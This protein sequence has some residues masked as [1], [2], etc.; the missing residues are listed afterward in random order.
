[1]TRD[2]SVWKSDQGCRETPLEA[3]MSSSE[4]SKIEPVT[5]AEATA[6]AM[7]QRVLSSWASD[8]LVLRRQGLDQP[9]W[10]T[11]I[12]EADEPMWRRAA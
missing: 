8:L 5:I 7:Y 12:D 10:R 6:R 4:D 1:M 9:G 2:R 3:V 11:A